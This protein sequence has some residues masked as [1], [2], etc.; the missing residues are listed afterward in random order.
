MC[1]FYNELHNIFGKKS[2]EFPFQIFD[3]ATTSNM[4]LN[5]TPVT[6]NSLDNQNEFNGFDSMDAF[7]RTPVIQYGD[8]EATVLDDDCV[9]VLT[10][11]HPESPP[12]P[13]QSL[14]QPTSSSSAE[15]NTQQNNKAV[16]DFAAKLKRA[17]P[18]NAIAQL[19]SIHSERNSYMKIKFDFEKEKFTKE[20]GLNEKK[21]AESVAGRRETMDLKRLE[22]EKD[23][24]IKKLELEKQERIE[25]YEIEMRYKHGSNTI[26]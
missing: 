21:F 6:E 16:E 14:T 9:E 1:R 10:A 22:I 15:K 3:T 7:G 19:A 5:S 2:S 23:E 20:F 24:R 18:K 13:I 12:S 11:S 17:A 25:R 4:I 8:S 26:V